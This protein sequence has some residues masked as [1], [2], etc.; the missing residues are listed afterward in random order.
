LEPLKR[1]LT[2][3]ASENVFPAIVLSDLASNFFFP[4][5]VYAFGDAIFLHLVVVLLIRGC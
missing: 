5:I 4:E 1:T 2:R 3:L